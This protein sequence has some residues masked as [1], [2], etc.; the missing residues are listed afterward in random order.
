[1]RVYAE[2]SGRQ[3]IGQPVMMG[4]MGGVAV[5]MIAVHPPLHMCLRN[6]SAC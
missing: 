1:M 5:K 6:L 2:Q 4:A 3:G